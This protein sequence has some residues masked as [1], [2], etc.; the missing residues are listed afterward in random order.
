[1]LWKVRIKKSCYCFSLQRWC[2]SGEVV[3]IEKVPWRAIQ[4]GLVEPL[5]VPVPQSVP[6][7]PGTYD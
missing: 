2:N 5:N 6:D 1:M 4:E 3:E 7:M